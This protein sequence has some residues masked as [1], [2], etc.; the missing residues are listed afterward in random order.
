MCRDILFLECAY[1]LL[2]STLTFAAHDTTSSALSRILHVLSLHPEAQAK[3]RTEVTE[4]RAASGD[5]PYEQLD[6]LPYLDAVVRETLR[7]LV[8]VYLIAHD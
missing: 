1:D 5:L 2:P 4:A 6:S 8:I 3:L 7:L